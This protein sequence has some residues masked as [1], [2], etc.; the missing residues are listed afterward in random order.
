M[1]TRNKSHHDLHISDALKGVVHP[2]VSHLHQDLLDGPAVVLGVHGLGGSELLG[3]LELRGVDVHTDDPGCPGNLAT[4][5]DS[6][7][8]GSKAKHGARGTSLDLREGEE[9]MW[10]S[11]KPNPI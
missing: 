3:R 7:A 11:L 1:W 5:D 2:P 10:E 6:Q 9:A 8:D 4:H